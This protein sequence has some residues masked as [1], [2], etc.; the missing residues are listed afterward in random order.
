MREAEELAS[1]VAAALSG[2]VR[3]LQRTRR[4]VPPDLLAVAHLTADAAKRGQPS[5]ALAWLVDLLNGPR[6]DPLLL[7]RPQAAEA[8][9]LSVRSLDRLLKSGGLASVKVEGATRVRRSDLDAY[10]ARLAG[11]FHAGVE[12]KG[13]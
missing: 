4:P 8:L 11:S 12:A 3:W 7:T 10:V 9:N 5:T 1:H 6:M 13:A 2:H